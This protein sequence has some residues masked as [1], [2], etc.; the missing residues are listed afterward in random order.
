[1]LNHITYLNPK[2]TEWVTFIHGAGGSYITWFK[3]IKAFKKHFNVLLLD[4]RGHG[5][6]LGSQD[7]GNV[8]YTFEFLANDIIELLNVLNIK[9]SHFVAISLGTIILRQLADKHPKRVSSMV[10][11]GAIMQLNFRS[12]VLVAIGNI[13]KKIIPY[14]TLYTFFAYII[15]P[16]KNHKP[17]RDVFIKEAKKLNQKEFIR[18]FS[19]ANQVNPV[20]KSFRQNELEIPIFYILG[21]QDAMFLPSI[22]ELVKTQK[23]YST[24]MVFDNC[25]HVV[26]LDKAYLFNKKVVEFISKV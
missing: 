11:A 6:S 20:L 10:L 1:M 3:Q 23:H 4:L 16:R 2:S 5:N 7:L 26:N 12:K 13:F 14:I 21:D 22:K 17:S 15:M 24:L 18:W 25:G 19:L 8:K 9:K